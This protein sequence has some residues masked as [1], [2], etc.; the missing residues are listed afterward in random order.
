[1]NIYKVTYK[2]PRGYYTPE[3]SITRGGFGTTYHVAFITATTAARAVEAVQAA[4]PELVV[5][6]NPKLLGQA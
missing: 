6:K 2:D 4:Y 3:D 5:L 1:M